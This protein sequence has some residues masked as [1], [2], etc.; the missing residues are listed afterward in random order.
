MSPLSPAHPLSRRRFVLGVGGLTVA[1]LALPGCSSG[2][3]S[4][5]TSGAG[6]T[7]GAPVEGGSLVFADIELQ[8]DF[9][10]QRAFN[11][12]QANVYRNIADR[13]TAFDPATGKVVPWI[14]SQWAVSPDNTEFTFTIRPGVTFS[15]G[16]PLDAAAVKANLDQLGLGDPAR[17]IIKNRDFIG[18][19][20]S[21][22]VGADQVLV[23]LSQPNA[24]FLK[25]TAAA[26]SSL[27]ALKTLALDYA[28][29]A[30]IE[31]VVGSG[32]FVFA[33]QVPDQ[34]LRFSKRADYAWPSS[35]ST[36]QGPAHLDEVVFRAIPEVGLRVGAVSSQQADVARGVQPTDEALAKQSG[37]ALVVAEAP[38]LTANWAAFRGG[39]PVVS[40]QAVRRALQIGFDRE[41]LKKT[42]L[43]ESYPLS[44][45]VLNRSA[46]GFTDLSDQIAYDAAGAKKLLDDA[47]WVPGSDGVR[48]KDGQRL[49]VAVAAS[50]RSVVI[51]P[52]F[53]FIESEWRKIGVELKNNAGD[54]AIFTTALGDK[55]YP[56]VGSRQFYL[57]GLAPLFS[58]EGNTNTYVSDAQLNELFGQE[59]AATD[60]ASRDAALTAV[61][62]R[63]VL[64][65]NLL[66]PLWDEVQV[67]AVGKGVHIT[68]DGGTAPLLQEAW[69]DA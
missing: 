20:S 26:T 50:S 29:Q 22:V 43:S 55:T 19:A 1:A 15:D 57:G 4:A 45:S 48:V 30:K 60:D 38:E 61:Q 65:T 25:A 11:Y 67:H 36:N 37:I 12:T 3:G 21:E 53:E 44:G 8:T 42:V 66:I 9:Q 16:T 68:F 5:Q 17:N 7:S 6:A 56:I 35:V 18:Y 63:L 14:A 58:A 54:S 52:A 69:K 10:T 13:L 51:K 40:D 28:G 41:A 49:S 39:A 32:P 62:E 47:G 64:G 27:V 46:P 59:R 33:S 34:E 24:D 2:S 23:R 31:N